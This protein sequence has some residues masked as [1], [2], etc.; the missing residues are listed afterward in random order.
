[1][2]IELYQIRLF[3][4]TVNKRGVAAVLLDVEVA[5]SREN[6]RLQCFVP[7]SPHLWGGRVVTG[8]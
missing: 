6:E 2:D 1:M 7:L 4:Y 5:I 3:F 8:S